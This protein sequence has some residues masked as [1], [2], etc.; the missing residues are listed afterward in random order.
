MP[1]TNIYFLVVGN[2]RLGTGHIYR[3]IIYR[4]EFNKLG[5]NCETYYLKGDK[6]VDDIYSSKNLSSI[7]IDSFKDIN[8][9]N[10]TKNIFILD[11]LDTSKELIQ[12]LKKN[13]KV[14]SFEDLGEGAITIGMGS[15]F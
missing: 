14:I 11:I 12:T 8:T 5:F 6:L 7:Q 3:S 2:Q 13:N 1:E 4:N 15:T 9:Q 10:P